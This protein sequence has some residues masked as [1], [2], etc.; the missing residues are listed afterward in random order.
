M[1]HSWISLTQHLGNWGLISVTNLLGSRINWDTSRRQNWEGKTQFQSGQNEPVAV[2]ILGGPREKQW[3]FA[4]LSLLLAG[5]C[6]YDAVAAAS[7]ER[8]TPT[9]IL[10]RSP[11]AFSTRVGGHRDTLP[12]GMNN[13]K[14]LRLSSLQ[15]DTVGLPDRYHVTQSN[16]SPLWHV[17]ILFL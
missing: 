16:K 5:D 12:C 14:I 6:I 1:V 8:R 10:F 13:C 4:Y 3:S 15:M 2:W 7:N 11:L 9:G 17:S